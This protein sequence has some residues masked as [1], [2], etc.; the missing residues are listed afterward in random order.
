MSATVRWTDDLAERL[1]GVA[2][3]SVRTEYPFHLAHLAHCA[4]DLRA[5]GVLHPVF[6]ASYDWHSCVHMVWTLARCLRLAPGLALADPI[7]Q[8]LD[9]RLTVAG[10]AAEIAYFETPGRGAF[11]RPYGWCWLLQLHAEL[12]RLAATHAKAARWRAALAPLAALIAERLLAHL[13]RL[14]YPVRAGTHGNTSFALVLALDYA[15]RL[16]QPALQSMIAERARTWFGADRDYPVAF[17][18]GG[19]EFLSPG[20]CEAALMARVLDAREFAAWWTGFAPGTAALSRWRSPVRVSDST[21]PKIVHLH[22][23]NLSRAWCWSVLRPHLPPGQAQA[24]AATI[25]AHLDASLAAATEGDY[26]GTHWLA[27]FAMLAITA[28]DL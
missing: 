18:P 21:D 11:E 19:D 2:L 24:I 28:S 14:D 6:G 27:S 17:E 12:D 23:L 20:L 25:D 22:G 10:M 8:H 26:A 4:D 1:A 7:G 15:R 13:P 16:R 9:A 3:A 5:P